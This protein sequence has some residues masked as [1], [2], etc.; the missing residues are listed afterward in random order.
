MHQPRDQTIPSHPGQIGIRAL[1]PHQV[2]A[3]RLL[4]MRVNDAKHALDFVLVARL[5]GRQF[6]V[7]EVAEPGFLAKVR[8]LAGHL[9]VEPLVGLE[10][11]GGGRVGQRVGLVV[12]FDQVL[13]YCAGLLRT[14]RKWSQ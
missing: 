7:V 12:S 5:G 6:L 1:I 4:Q 9:E 11:F 3:P 14:E 8:T 13:G 2:L 10:L